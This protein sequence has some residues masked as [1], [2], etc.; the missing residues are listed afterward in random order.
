MLMS[1]RAADCAVIEGHLPAV[2]GGTF[3]VLEVRFKSSNA[4]MNNQTRAARLKILVKKPQEHYV[5]SQFMPKSFFFSLFLRPSASSETS[6]SE[7][8][9]LF[10]IFCIPEINKVQFLLCLAQHMEI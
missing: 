3:H 6:K 8:K 7:F 4:E 9:I 1:E 5:R 2:S 10:V